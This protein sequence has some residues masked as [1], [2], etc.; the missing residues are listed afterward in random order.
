[1]KELCLVLTG[2]ISRLG[3]LLRVILPQQPGEL[4]QLRIRIKCNV[5]H[6]L[7]ALVVY[8][9]F[10]AGGLFQ[11]T[12]HLH[13]KHRAGKGILFLGGL[14]RLGHFAAQRFGLAHAHILSNDLVRRG[15][16]LLR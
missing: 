1:M 7:A 14:R 11:G 9:H 3:S 5:Q 16:H 10:A 8:M 15:G 13:G 6:A 12:L 2:R 4:L